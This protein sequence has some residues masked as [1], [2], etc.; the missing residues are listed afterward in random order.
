MPE[1]DIWEDRQQDQI[2]GNNAL[3]KS[4]KAEQNA[5]S[6]KSSPTCATKYMSGGGGRPRQNLTEV[7]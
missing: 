1:K 2:T 6:V 5:E 3:I 4:V 7:E